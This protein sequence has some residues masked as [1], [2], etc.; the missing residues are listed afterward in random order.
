MNVNSRVNQV[1]SFGTPKIEKVSEVK[2]RFDISNNDETSVQIIAP[3]SIGSIIDTKPFRGVR[4][5]EKNTL[6]KNV[7][8][9]YEYEEEEKGYFIDF[10][11]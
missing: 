3:M 11:V 5:E 1:K 4:F 2:L 9:A 10:K 6:K 7:N 8:E